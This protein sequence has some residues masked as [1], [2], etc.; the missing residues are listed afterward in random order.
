MSAKRAQKPL[1]EISA[2][3]PKKQRLTESTSSP[4]TFAPLHHYDPEHDAEPRLPEGT[5]L[6]PPSIFSLYS[7][8]EIL[9]KIAD[10][11][12]A[13]AKLKQQLIPRWYLK[14][15]KWKPKSIAEFTTV[16][17]YDNPHGTRQEASTR[18]L[19]VADA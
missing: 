9:Q 19:L 1:A 5:K 10:S 4:D 15:R 12:N 8:D 11:T 6:S 2:N 14:Y 13:Y 3:A 16:P 17:W 7:N 18:Q